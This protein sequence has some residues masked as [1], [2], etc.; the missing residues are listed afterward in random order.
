MQN[1]LTKNDLSDIHFYLMSALNYYT[2][3]AE[4]EE[5][6]DLPKEDKNENYVYKQIQRIN[7]LQDKISDILKEGV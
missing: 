4:D 3:W 2:Q 1:N 5:I 6:M 7:K